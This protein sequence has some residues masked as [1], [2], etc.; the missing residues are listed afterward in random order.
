M[1]NVSFDEEPQYASRATALQ[2]TNQ[3]SIIG[4]MYRL[5]L[6]KTEKDAN[7]VMGT[8]IVVCL[9]VTATMFVFVQPHQSTAQAEA[10][11]RDAQRM[12][13]QMQAQAQIPAQQ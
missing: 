4:L 6:A 9:I 5:G 2:S 13:A 7:V 11:Q 1:A 8:V 3:G 10:L 12:S